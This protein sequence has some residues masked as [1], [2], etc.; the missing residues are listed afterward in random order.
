MQGKGCCT[1]LSVVPGSPL[2]AGRLGSSSV[3]YAERGKGIPLAMADA[4]ENL[5]THG[6]TGV[7]WDEPWDGNERPG[8]SDAI[9]SVCLG[10]LFSGS[11]VYCNVIFII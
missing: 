8:L 11:N 2:S 5:R 3:Y 1:S 6:G 7:M 9:A 10:H 4:D